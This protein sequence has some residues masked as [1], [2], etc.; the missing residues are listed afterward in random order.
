[1]GGYAV[2]IYPFMRETAEKWYRGHPERF[3]KVDRNN[4]TDSDVQQYW[5]IVAWVARVN[6]SVE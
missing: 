3:K 5:Q 1:M 6:E 4:V 2:I